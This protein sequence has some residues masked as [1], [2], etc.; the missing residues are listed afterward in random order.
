MLDLLLE[1][2][3]F[4]VY[5]VQ[6]FR[7][8]CSSGSAAFRLLPVSFIGVAVLAITM[9]APT[10]SAQ[11]VPFG[12]QDVITT[13]ADGATSVYAADIDGDGDLDVLSAFN[14]TIAWYENERVTE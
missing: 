8:T 13:G 1:F 10:A 4:A 11:P 5:P 7:R 3:C 14:N 12:P 9:G 2:F 6:F